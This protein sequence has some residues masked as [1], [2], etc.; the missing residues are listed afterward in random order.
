MRKRRW[1]PEYRCEKMGMYIIEK[2]RWCTEPYP[3][4]KCEGCPHNKG[5]KKDEDRI[6]DQQRAIEH[7]QE[8]RRRRKERKNAEKSGEN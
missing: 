6:L 7:K 3:E 5:Y 2:I 4:R 1:L 8:L